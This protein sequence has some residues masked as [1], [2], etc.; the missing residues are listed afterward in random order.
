MKTQSCLS[1]LRH[2][3]LVSVTALSSAAAQA[4]IVHQLHMTFTNGSVFD[5]DLTFKNDYSSLQG[6]SGSLLGGTQVGGPGY[7][8][9]SFNWTWYAAFAE[10]SGDEDGNTSTLEDYLMQGVDIDH[11][12][13]TQIGISW[14]VPVTGT[15]P[16]LNLNARRPYASL[17]NFHRIATYQF[18]QGTPANTVPEPASLAVAGLALT[19]MPLLSG[20]RRSKV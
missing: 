6:V 20:R 4:D 11:S 5:G 12:D 7:G 8:T 17:D 16:A 18:G 3:A 10:P 13:F 2:L 19:C 14:W 9:V 1:A 15:A